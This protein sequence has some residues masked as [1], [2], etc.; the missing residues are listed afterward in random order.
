MK[1]TYTLPSR[2]AKQNTRRPKEMFSDVFVHCMLLCG[3]WYLHSYLCAEL[4]DLMTAH[5]S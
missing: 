5:V 3:S 1:N 4:L 2:V